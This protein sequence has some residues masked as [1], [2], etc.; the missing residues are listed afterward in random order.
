MD[1]SLPPHLFMHKQTTK[2]DETQE[3]TRKILDRGFQR[4]F[5]MLLW[6]ARGVFPEAVVAT[7]MAGRLMADPTA[8]AWDALCWLLT[9]TFQR[10]SRGIR[11]N[12]RGNYYMI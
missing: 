7:S 4:L 8:K 11:F 9:C 1:T 12:S 5:G 10:K 3:T 2:T 6:A